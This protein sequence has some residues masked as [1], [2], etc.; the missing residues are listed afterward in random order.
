MGPAATAQ[1]S[2]PDPSATSIL[3]ELRTLRVGRRGLHWW[4]WICRL[5]WIRSQ[6]RA[7]SSVS[8][9]RF[10]LRDFGAQTGSILASEREQ[11]GGREWSGLK[12]FGPSTPSPA[13]ARWERLRNSVEI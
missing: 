7:I 11:G 4:R 9:C 5:E 12:W 3:S 8:G 2:R 13:A 6:G 10:R 1:S